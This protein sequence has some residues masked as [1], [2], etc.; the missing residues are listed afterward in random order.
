MMAY[1]R[2]YRSPRLVLLYPAVPG[3]SGR[4]IE[5]HGLAEGRERLEIATVAV[6][7]SETELRE[8]LRHLVF[9][10]TPA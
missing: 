6:E 1:A 10:R 7:A 9:P 8:E 5:M 3:E 2:I 4:K